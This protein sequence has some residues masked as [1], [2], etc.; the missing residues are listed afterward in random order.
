M[1]HHI[2]VICLGFQVVKN[3]V[4]KEFKQLITMIENG[5]EEMQEETK[6]IT[7]KT[8]YSY[9]DACDCKDPEC[10]LN[11][12]P[13]I[14]FKR[15][16]ITQKDIESLFG[17]V[18]PRDWKHYC[19]KC[20]LLMKCQIKDG[21]IKVYCGATQYS[22]CY[23]NVQPQIIQK[24]LSEH[25]KD[26]LSEHQGVIDECWKILQEFLSHNGQGEFWS[27]SDSDTSRGGNFFIRKEEI[28]QKK[29]ANDLSYLA[30]MIYEIY[31]PMDDGGFTPFRLKNGERYPLKKLK[32][33][34]IF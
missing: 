6:N 30:R 20:N 19:S 17:I 5:D 32:T 1:I 4:A 27:S 13:K 21:T 12:A 31:E 7:A 3:C 33:A 26:V 11:H 22:K 23:K 14:V 9:T 10:D 34:K 16:R 25:Q 24:S 18:T 8:V 28:E 29:A 2:S 15:S